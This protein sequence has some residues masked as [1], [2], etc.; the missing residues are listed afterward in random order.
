MCEKGWTMIITSW[1]FHFITYGTQ[2]PE[3]SKA[4]EIRNQMLATKLKDVL[5]RN[6]TL[7]SLQSNVFFVSPCPGEDGTDRLTYA[8]TGATSEM[9]VF[10]NP[11]SDDLTIETGMEDQIS[12][13][14]IYSMSGVL[15]KTIIGM[16]VNG[17]LHVSMMGIAPGAYFMNLS[18][19][20]RVQSCRLIKLED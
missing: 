5:Q 8:Q 4:A 13:I 15:V 12:N 2:S 17:T 9:K 7:T 10:P 1:L 6:S 20:G 18:A 16:P 11:V 3:M 14:S 19:G